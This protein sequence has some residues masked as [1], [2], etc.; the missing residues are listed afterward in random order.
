MNTYKEINDT[1]QHHSPTT[2]FYQAFND[3]YRHFNHALFQNSLPECMITVQRGK[4]YYGYFAPKRWHNTD[5]NHAHEIAMNT[6]YFHEQTLIEVLQTLVHEMCH[7]WQAEFGKPSR[8]GYHNREWADKMESIGLM[9]SN[10]N[11]EGGKRTGQKMGD[12]PLIGKPFMHTCIELVQSGFLISWVD[13][14]LIRPPNLPGN[15]EPIADP[16]LAILYAPLI[17]PSKSTPINIT[18]SSSTKHKYTCPCGNNLW[19]KSGL[20]IMCMQCN[21]LFTAENW[22]SFLKDISPKMLDC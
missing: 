1:E 22:K 16:T 6:A 18:S 12:Y 11:K 20:S 10:T 3:A 4:S 13:R 5:G 17:D 9:P 21:K 14:S 2:Q 7:L 8:N 19:G 15:A